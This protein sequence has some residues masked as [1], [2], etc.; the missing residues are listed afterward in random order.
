MLTST[1]LRS[2]KR[3]NYK[4]VIDRKSRLLNISALNNLFQ[5]ADFSFSHPRQQANYLKSL[6]SNIAKEFRL[7]KKQ[8]SLYKIMP[9]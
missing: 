7:D 2:R 9:N 4:A 1:N 6:H 8:L 5:T 3:H